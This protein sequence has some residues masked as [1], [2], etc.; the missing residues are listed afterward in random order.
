MCVSR[1]PSPPHLNPE[2]LIVDEVLAVG[3][4]EF[5]KKCLGKMQDVAESGRTV[6]FVSHNLQAVKSLCSRVVFLQ[7][8]SVIAD[9]GTEAG[10]QRYL[11]RHDALPSEQVWDDLHSR[12]GD[13]LFR[14]ASIRVL[15]DQ[16]RPAGIF[17]SSK[18]VLVEI[19]F[20]LAYLHDLLCIGFDLSRDDGTC[21][22]RS[23]QTDVDPADLPALTPGK[24]QLTCFVDS[25]LL[26]AGTY[27]I[28]VKVSI[29]H[30]KWIAIVDGAAQFEVV[31]DHGTSPFLKT[32]TRPGP[33]APIFH[34]SSAGGWNPRYC[35]P[36]Q[37]KEGLCDA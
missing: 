13:D 2:I 4:A 24:N 5:Q 30:Q 6:L 17:S 22:F 27:V 32:G 7:Q 23:Y 37:D 35:H 26:N 25:N 12:P 29:H 28:N 11:T 14:L 33:L 36:T 18:P 31:F 21:A 1:L 19:E 16:R 10:I 3:D 9:G 8:G 34:W 20:D 15:D